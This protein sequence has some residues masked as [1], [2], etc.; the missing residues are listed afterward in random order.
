MAE[1]AVDPGKTDGGGAPPS[2]PSSSFESF[3][4]QQTDES[5]RRTTERREAMEPPL[6]T[7]RDAERETNSLQPPAPVALPPKPDLQF[8]DPAQAFGSA[9]GW[10]AVFGGFLT[11]KP[12]ET[13]LNAS[14]GVMNAWRKRDQEQA[15]YS[16][17]EWE[18]EIQNARNLHT[19]QMDQYRGALEKLRDRKSSAVAELQ[20]LSAAFKDETGT[21]LL[22]ARMFGEFQRHL[23]AQDRMFVQLQKNGPD[24]WR[25]AQREALFEQITTARASG[26][27]AKVE[28]AQRS[29]AD[30]NRIFPDKGGAAVLKVDATKEAAVAK[31]DKITSAYET[32][33][34][35]PGNGEKDLEEFIPIWQRLNGIVDPEVKAALKEKEISA[36]SVSKDAISSAWRTYHEQNPQGSWEDFVKTYQDLHGTMSPAD[37]KALKEQEIEARKA[38]AEARPRSA[39]QQAAAKFAAENPHATSEQWAGFKRSM[40]ASLAAKAQNKADTI[41]LVSDRIDTAIGILD[42]D[43]GTLF[44]QSG[45]GGMVDRPLESVLT[46]LG[47]QDTAPAH[48]YQFELDTIKTMVPRILSSSAKTAKDER[49]KLDTIVS[50]L[51]A[52]Q[53][54]KISRQNL[55]ELKDLLAQIKAKEFPDAG[56]SYN[57]ADDVKAALQ[58]NKIDYATAKKI[59]HDKFGFQ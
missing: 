12:L 35:N 16:L 51:S 40:S 50:G 36:K 9:A 4:Q 41:D 19:F 44:G 33:K 30:F 59:L 37:K 23:D 13:A 43:I 32:W 25:Q 1:A 22:N 31:A 10:L 24:Q 52:G 55:T 57:S 20:A 53:S 42:A 56:G 48:L 15:Q 46:A 54:A 39:D 14:A 27:P 18:G 26:D 3:L 17:K 45:L 47:M 49:A 11:K 21:Q 29:M 8:R 28:E 58:A 7:I 34:K 38:V 5:A 6:K 2:A